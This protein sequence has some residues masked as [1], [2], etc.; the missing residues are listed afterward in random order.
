MT[1]TSDF[2]DIA[3]RAAERAS[4]KGGHAAEAAAQAAKATTSI[5]EADAFIQ[6]AIGLLADPFA[7]RGAIE[8]ALEALHEAGQRTSTARYLACRAAEISAR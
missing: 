2:A 3:R 1:T 6:Q 4:A 8:A 7:S 5:C